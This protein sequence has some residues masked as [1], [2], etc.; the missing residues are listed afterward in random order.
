MIN[1]RITK[2]FCL[3]ENIKFQK[4]HECG[5]ELSPHRIDT[6]E[7]NK[8]TINFIQY[9]IQMGHLRLNA[10]SKDAHLLWICKN[11]WPTEIRKEI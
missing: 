5:E 4:C 10:I 9:L 8:C 3:D 1:I 6:E 11:C 7:L 2:V